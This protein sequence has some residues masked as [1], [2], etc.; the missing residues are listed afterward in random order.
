MGDDG[1]RDEVAPVKAAAVEN[2]PG[3]AVNSGNALRRESLNVAAVSLEKSAAA[4][5]RSGKSLHRKSLK[6]ESVE[7]CESAGEAVLA[8]PAAAAAAAVA[9]EAEA[10]AAAAK[11]GV[12]EAA[13]TSDGAAATVDP[14]T[15]KVAQLEAVEAAR[16]A[17][18]A[19]VVASLA[20]REP[21]DRKKLDAKCAARSE[22]EAMQHAAIVSAVL[23]NESGWQAGVPPPTA[24]GY[25]YYDAGDRRFAVLADGSSVTLCL[26]EHRELVLLRPAS[27]P[28]LGLT[29]TPPPSH[30][31]TANAVAMR[32][33]SAPQET[34]TRSGVVAKLSATKGKFTSSPRWQKRFLTLDG[35]QLSYYKN[36]RD[37]GSSTAARGT[38]EL[39]TGTK[40][41][42]CEPSMPLLADAFK[43]K[44]RKPTADVDG[45]VDRNHVFAIHLPLVIGRQ[46][47]AVR[48]VL[49][50][51]VVDIQARLDE[52][53]EATRA[54]TYYFQCESA[55]DCEAWV[56]A[57]KANMAHGLASGLLR[58]SQLDSAHLLLSQGLGASS[59]VDLDVGALLDDLLAGRR[60][61]R[62]RMSSQPSTSA[63]AT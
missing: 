59:L 19:A 3:A 12:G 6:V 4:A 28:Y 63:A 8:G 13:G 55:K 1:K 37:A 38:I 11:A 54:R 60:R 57:V 51:S 9:A 29:R 58:A 52:A 50:G 26:G 35:I 42:A 24:G 33:L 14:R 47:A 41:I 16:L 44:S 15:T 7:L 17:T 20:D 31:I 36:E 53:Y 48:D 56:A 61:S 22:I 10:E 25:T 27:K 23:N 2:S 39:I 34:V 62:R 40:I 43:L 45:T 21:S 46:L 30:W 18:V 32:K 5:V 49:E